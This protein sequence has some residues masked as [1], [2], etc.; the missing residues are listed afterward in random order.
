MV[1]MLINKYH[2]E[3]SDHCKTVTTVFITSFPLLFHFSS[4]TS[5]RMFENLSEKKILNVIHYS[6]FFFENVIMVSFSVWY[7]PTST[8]HIELLAKIVLPLVFGGFAIGLLF[9]A[10]Y[11]NFFHTSKME[12]ANSNNNGNS[13]NND[14]HNDEG[15]VSNNQ[16][17][18]AND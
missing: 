8:P 7:D 14:Q 13:N 17:E 10:L 6:I 1:V 12:K 16:C 5:K 2:D 3:N 4:F 18:T 15:T 9:R 11:Y